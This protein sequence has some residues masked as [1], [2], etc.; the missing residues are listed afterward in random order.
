MAMIVN[1]AWVDPETKKKLGDI[2]KTGLLQES[3]GSADSESQDPMAAMVAQ[4]EANLAM[5]E[6]LKGKAEEALQ[7]IRDEETKKQGEHDVQVMTLK[8]AIALAE[9]NVDDAK[10]A[11][12]RLAQE[13]AEAEEEKA[14]VEASK[15]ADEKSLAETKLEC[16]QTSAAWAA[17]QKEAAAEMAAIEKAKEIL[18]SRVTVLLVQAKVTLHAKSHSSNDDE[19]EEDDDDDVDEKRVKADSDVKASVKTQKTRQ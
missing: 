6:G 18:S 1:A 3:E 17:R 9:N 15:A 14:D 11:R 2:S 8:Q 4:N 7:R 10:K 12:S 19:D 16:E 5:F 13:K